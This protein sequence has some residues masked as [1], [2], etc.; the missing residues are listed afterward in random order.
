MSSRPSR[1]QTLV[2]LIV[3]GLLAVGAAPTIA[4]RVGG[5]GLGPDD[6]ADAPLGQPPAVDDADGYAYVATREDGSPLRYDP[7]APLHVVINPDGEIDDGTRMIEE[8]VSSVALATGLQILIDPDTDARPGE[9]AEA[10]GE[11]RPP[12]VLV[13][14]ADAKESKEL[15]GDIAGIGGSAESYDGDWYD[16]GEIVLDAPDLAAIAREEGYEVARGVVMHEL[17]HVVGLDHVDVKG[18]L[19]QPEGERGIVDWGPGDR[20][21]LA[22]LGGGACR[23]Y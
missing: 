15:K 16:T 19:M 8:S 5:P 1:V 4:D 10:S 9:S 21:G 11:R 13:A 23:D 12:P 17:G 6:V 2:V 7:C 18:E 14:W 3:A 20:A 22:S